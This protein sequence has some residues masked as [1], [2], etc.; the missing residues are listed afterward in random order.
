MKNNEKEAPSPRTLRFFVVFHFSIHFFVVLKKG[1]VDQDSVR[2][3]E[4]EV[5]AVELHVLA[6][7]LLAFDS[8]FL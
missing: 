1:A 6:E 4:L 7:I 5:V 3:A 8:H 2:L